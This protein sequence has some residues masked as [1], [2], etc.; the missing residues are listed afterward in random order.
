[1][2]RLRHA[3]AA[4]GRFLWDFLVGD[5]PELFVA[6]VAVVLLALVL[7]HHR[8]AAIV[9]LPVVVVAVLVSSTFRGRRRTPRAA[10]RD[11]EE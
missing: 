10:P 5:T 7:R 4:F 1:V 6:V 8:V 3:A 2:T 11:L 9:L